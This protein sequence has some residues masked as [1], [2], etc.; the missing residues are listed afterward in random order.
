MFGSVLFFV[1]FVIVDAYREEVVHSNVSDV[2]QLAV[3]S[4]CSVYSAVDS[5]TKLIMH[6]AAT[7][8]ATRDY[9]SVMSSDVVVV[10]DNCDVVLFG[11]P[12][13]NRVSMWKPLLD[14]VV[15]F[16]PQNIV[17][18]PESGASQ[19]LFMKNYSVDNLVNV[20]R[21]PISNTV[22]RFGFSLDIQGQTWVVGAPG[23][24]NGILGNGG[25]P[26]YA[27]V[28]QE[29]ELHSCRSI[30][31]MSCYPESTGCVSG[32]EN[33]LKY[34]GKLKS[35][36]AS[37]FIPSY[38]KVAWQKSWGDGPNETKVLHISDV[39]QVQKLCLPIEKPYY[40][41]TGPMSNKIY[42]EH[43][44]RYQQFGY[45]V[46]LTG[47]MGT[48]GST[49]FISAP[50]DT[51]RFM[52]NGAGVNYG[53][54]YI[55]DN[56]VW[57]DGQESNT[58]LSWW[59]PSVRT[60]LTISLELATYQAFGRDISAS[61]DFL[62]VS[63]YPLYEQTNKPFVILFRCK[64][65][66]NDVEL[67]T[68]GR[69]EVDAV[70]SC[71]E[72]GGISID[73]IPGNPLEYLGVNDITY[74][75]GKTLWEYVPV[76]ANDFQNKF[77][78]DNIGVVGSNV[79]IA[80]PKNGKVYRFDIEGDFREQHSSGNGHTLP[81]TAFSTNS[82]HWIVENG[83]NSV[84]HYWDCPHGYV[85]A[86]KQCQAVAS[87]YYSSDGWELYSSPC[88]RN[89]TTTNEASTRCIPWS[90]PIIPGLTLTTMFVYMAIIVVSTFTCCG[91]LAAWQYLCVQKDKKK[92][93]Y[94]SVSLNERDEQEN[95]G[96]YT[97]KNIVF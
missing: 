13:K 74:L 46:S 96:F 45:S 59:Q 66:L 8:G 81:K 2:R 89:Y 22:D 97:Q 11:Y 54:V 31:E 47:A 15:H 4:G 51:T 64:E 79:I 20:T 26:G 10:N 57:P 24:P 73:N 92:S 80:D 77:I 49:L 17:T 37:Y 71:V 75:D 14:I 42:N 62:A 86:K 27:F 60:P 43:R 48:N 32:L 18:L 25:T 84:V 53:R 19:A 63:A 21:V 34:Y 67:A 76:P 23:T 94:A 28:F 38:K 30:Y 69:Q 52:E 65:S 36:W 50:G 1:V 88:P 44:E 39:R 72:V 93:R 58:T 35:D 12:K 3:S 16:V 40:K 61:R 85:G 87:G 41:G 78:G 5:G 90:A 7:S 55:W 9:Y 33:W 6:S 29:N 68:G 91:V 82:Q 95:S 83:V 70:S 56:I